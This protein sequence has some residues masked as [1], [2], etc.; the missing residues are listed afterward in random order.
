ME[1]LRKEKL[2]DAYEVARRRMVAEQLVVHGIRDPRVLEAMGRVQR[3][4]FVSPGM[5][6]QA[7]LDRPLHI[8]EG[9]TISQPLMVAQMTEL[10]L[11]TK[12]DRILEIGTGSGYQ[13]AVLAELAD[14]V[15]TVERLSSLSIRA[16]RVLH[17]LGYRN[18]TLR[19]GDGTLGWPEQAPYHGIIVTAGA[20]IIP[21]GLLSQLCD[22]GRLVIP[23]GDEERQELLLMTKRGSSFDRKAITGCRFVKLIGEK[24]WK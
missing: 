2:R 9:Q 22:G 11:P 5:E 19:I 15:Y 23:V 3:H 18:V 21:E 4:C 6:N 7:Y 14:H 13:T 12:Q 24:G 8:G 16:R 1:A 17:R 10:L 20:P